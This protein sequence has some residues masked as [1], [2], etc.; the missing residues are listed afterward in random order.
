MYNTLKQNMNN[1][2]DG[3]QTDN[4]TMSPNKCLSLKAIKTIQ[5]PQVGCNNNKATAGLNMN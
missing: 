3:W 4:N 2:R 1:G 5:Q